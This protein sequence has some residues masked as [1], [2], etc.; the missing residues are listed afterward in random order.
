MCQDIDF[1]QQNHELEAVLGSVAGHR[2]WQAKV[3][4]GWEADIH[5]LV[6]CTKGWA[7][8]EH[9]PRVN[10]DRRK[11]SGVQKIDMIT[12]VLLNVGTSVASCRLYPWCPIMAGKCT[13]FMVSA[14]SISK[15]SRLLVCSTA[16]RMEYSNDSNDTHSFWTVEV[17]QLASSAVFSAI[18]EAVANVHTQ[19]VCSRSR[20]SIHSTQKMKP[21]TR[22]LL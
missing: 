17:S 11:L 5:V 13:G 4:G 16:T 6:G 10:T 14:T 18:N 12:L 21:S 2:S 3:G 8:Q 19:V 9:H 1:W 7:C 22:Q 20:G 15:W